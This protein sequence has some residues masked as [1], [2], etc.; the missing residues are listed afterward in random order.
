MLILTRKVGESI[1]IGDEITVTVLEVRGSHVRLGIRAPLQTTV[2]RQEVY[3][4]V[5]EENRRAA[6]EGPPDL[7]GLGRMLGSYRPAHAKEGTR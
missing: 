2:H 5:Q 7:H 3:L 6:M 1:T 4:R